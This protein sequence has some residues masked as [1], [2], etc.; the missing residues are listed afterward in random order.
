MDMSPRNGRK[1]CRNESIDADP[2]R[3]HEDVVVATRGV[4][5]GAR[6]PVSTVTT[7]NSVSIA[8]PH[9]PQ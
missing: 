7:L 8:L 1:R 3:P 5:I 9:S 6:P 4:G 2:H